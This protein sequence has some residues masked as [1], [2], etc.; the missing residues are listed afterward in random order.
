LYCCRTGWKMRGASIKAASTHSVEANHY[1]AGVCKEYLAYLDQM[2]SD[3]TITIA[4]LNQRYFNT[5]QA[6]FDPRARR[7]VLAVIRQFIQGIAGANLGGKGLSVS[8]WAGD[9]ELFASVWIIC[10]SPSSSSRSML[11]A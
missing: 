9:V 6:D 5:T 10:A 7:K 8:Q 3:G 2:L 11:R 1:K 4:D